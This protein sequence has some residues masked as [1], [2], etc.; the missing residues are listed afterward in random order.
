[1]LAHAHVIGRAFL[2]R[3][4][5]SIQVQTNIRTGAS[6][7]RTTNRM[8]EPEVDLPIADGVIGQIHRPESH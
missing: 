2:A 6:V 7:H 8:C 5:E 1:M 3:R 4:G